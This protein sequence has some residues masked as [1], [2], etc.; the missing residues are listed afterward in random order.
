MVDFLVVG[1]GCIVGAL[2]VTHTLLSAV[3]GV[4]GFSALWSIIEIFDQQKEWI[5]VGFLLALDIKQKQKQ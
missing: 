1:I 2:F 4:T 3:M 5:R